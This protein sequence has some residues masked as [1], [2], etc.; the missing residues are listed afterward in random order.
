[1][2]K[3]NSQVIN[4]FSSKKLSP[5]KLGLRT[6]RTLT[7]QQ[8]SGSNEQLSKKRALGVS[9]T[10]NTNNNQGDK[11]GETPSFKEQLINSCGQVNISIFIN[12]LPANK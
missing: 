12:A 7:D 5:I 11:L 9:N 10:F 8:N 2:D 1:M 4:Y 3:E 6:K